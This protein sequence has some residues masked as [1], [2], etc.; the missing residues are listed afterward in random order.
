MILSHEYLLH[1]LRLIESKCSDRSD[2]HSTIEYCLPKATDV[3]QPV[4]YSVY[5][6]LIFMCLLFQIDLELK[7]Y[8]TS[9]VCRVVDLINAPKKKELF[10]LVTFLEKA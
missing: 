8:I 2:A 5:V 4:N 1:Q 6:L 10:I 7:R 3:N 9:I